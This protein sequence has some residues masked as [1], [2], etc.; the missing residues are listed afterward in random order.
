M[1]VNLSAIVLIWIVVGLVTTVGCTVNQG[2]APPK[3][4]EL[5]NESKPVFEYLYAVCKDPS[6]DYCTVMNPV[7]ADL[8]KQMGDYVEFRWI[9][10]TKRHTN[11]TI[12]QIETKY[13]SKGMLPGVP[14]YVING[15]YYTYGVMDE[16]TLKIWICNTVREIENRTIPPCENYSS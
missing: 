15:K 12:K 11:D 14:T 1:N 13:K 5:T 9:N 2:T 16:E 8:E 10:L 6:K 4:P 3:H 7:I